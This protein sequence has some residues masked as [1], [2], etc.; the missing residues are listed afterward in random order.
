V[1]TEMP[2]C[3]FCGKPGKYFVASNPVC[4]NSHI[5]PLP[6]GMTRGE[7]KSVIHQLEV[8]R[9]ACDPDGPDWQDYDS[10]V[11]HLYCILRHMKGLPR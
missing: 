10:A 2:A 9:E 7:L 4:G 11:V 5:A 1:T 8:A 6:K 3:V